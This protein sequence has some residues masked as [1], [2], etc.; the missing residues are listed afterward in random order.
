MML[1]A[2]RML[3]LTF[4]ENLT[5]LGLAW[6]ALGKWFRMVRRLMPDFAYVAVPERQDRGA[7]HFHL[8]IRGFRNVSVL[9]YLWHK[10]VGSGSVNIGRGGAWKRGAIARYLCKYMSE[11]F[12][13]GQAYR[14]RYSSAGTIA[15]P[16]RVRLY[17]PV[18]IGCDF[19]RAMRAVEWYASACVVR[20]WDG[21]SE[22]S[23]F[24][25]MYFA[26]Y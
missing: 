8:A 14:K 5:D 1:R 9:R 12:D 20:S 4:R 25:L 24:R 11:D 15:E 16:S 23:S 7:W 2:D 18:G 22:F 6:K 10:V 21:L 26:T 19:I 13:T 17:I 3:S